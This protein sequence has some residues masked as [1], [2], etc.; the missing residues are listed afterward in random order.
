M[1]SG[2]PTC[3]VATQLVVVLQDVGGPDQAISKHISFSAF[4]P[5]SMAASV[6]LSYVQDVDSVSPGCTTTQEPRSALREHDA[7]AAL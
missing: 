7:C 6:V 1:Q 5:E 4:G 2:P 3:Q